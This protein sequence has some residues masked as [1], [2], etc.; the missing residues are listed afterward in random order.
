M[1]RQM[2]HRLCNRCLWYMNKRNKIC[3]VAINIKSK[4]SYLCH[5]QRRLKYIKLLKTNKAISIVVN[6]IWGTFLA[7]LVLSFIF[8]KPRRRK[9]VSHFRKSTFNVCYY[10]YVL[11]ISENY[12]CPILFLFHIPKY[13]RVLKL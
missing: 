5:T 8:S 13:V 1:I 2:Q 9:N 7:L 11:F 3:Y 6:I 10:N 12:N 4:I